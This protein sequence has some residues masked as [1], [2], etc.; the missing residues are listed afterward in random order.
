[1]RKNLFRQRPLL[2]LPQILILLMVIV[3]LF[4]GLDLTRRAQAGRL[5]GAGEESL[6]H[7]ISLEATRQ[8]ELQATLSYVQSDEYVSAYA[9]DEG[10]YIQPGEKRI[11]PMV[12]EATPGPPPQAAPTPDPALSARPWQ[13]WW[14]LL[15]DAPQPSRP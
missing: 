13:A 3:A 2:T 5:V 15:S 4:V 10:G 12:V 7:E 8:I 9:R 14:Q 6:T 1:M 11:V